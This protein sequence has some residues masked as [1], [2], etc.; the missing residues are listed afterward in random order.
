MANLVL[1]EATHGVL[2]PALHQDSL[3]FRL[4]RERICWIEHIRFAY[5]IDPELANV[6]HQALS[7]VSQWERKHLQRLTT[8]WWQIITSSR[9]RRNE[10]KQMAKRLKSVTKSDIIDFGE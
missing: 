9:R 1:S 6:H 10:S 8:P 5:L 3:E 7:N 4:R 2:A